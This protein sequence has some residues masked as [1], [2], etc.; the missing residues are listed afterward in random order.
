MIRLDG[1]SVSSI[2]R[3][4]V[5]RNSEG[6]ISIRPNSLGLPKTVN[7]LVNEFLFPFGVKGINKAAFVNMW[8]ISV[9]C[10]GNVMYSINKAAFV[11]MWAITSWILRE[12]STISHETGSA[13]LSYPKA[14]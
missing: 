9:W 12:M 1:L 2:T 8:A 10:Q 5:I 11:N 7:C 6:G 4:I 13:R 14:G 3:A